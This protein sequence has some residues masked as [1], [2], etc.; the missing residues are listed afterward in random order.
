M[1]GFVQDKRFKT[2]KENISF[3]FSIILFAVTIYVTK[4]N[5]GLSEKNDALVV[6]ITELQVRL[7]QLE[8]QRNYYLPQSE[9]P[10]KET[11]VSKK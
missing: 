6:N 11:I 4:V 2:A 5:S 10:S 8:T 9:K 3:F 1:M 7:Q